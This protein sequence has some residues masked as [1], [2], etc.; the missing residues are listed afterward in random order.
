MVTVTRF[1]PFDPAI[2]EDPYPAYHRLRELRP[3]LHDETT[4]TW[5]LS[6]HRD[7]AW[8]LRDDRFSSDRRKGPSFE[9][10]PD[11]YPM[12]PSMLFVDPPEHTRL[13]GLVSRAFTP[14][15]VDQLRGRVEE[16]TAFL[17]DQA[18]AARAFDLVELFA[19][20][21]PVVV[22]AELLGV[23]PE[24]RLR[25]QE[26]S[27][28]LIRGLDPVTD[29]AVMHDLFL[30]REALHAYLREIVERR[31]TERRDDLIS[32]LLAL[33]ELSEPELLVMCQLLLV[34]GHETTVNLLGNGVLTLLE[35]PDQVER[36]L[37]EP[38]L[39]RPAVEELLR[40]TSPVQ[41][42]GRLALADVEI[43]GFTV[44]AGERVMGLVGAANRDP[45]V[46]PDPDRLDLG[47]DPNPHLSFGRGIHFCLG[48]PLARLEAQVAL[49]ALFGRFPGLR[50]AGRPELRDMVVLRG[51]SRLPVNV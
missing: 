46:F 35:N 50:L 18:E 16:V 36:L 19:Y 31:R 21:L 45:S 12:L 29:P 2:R 24:D 33:D 13:R 38:D 7:V 5:I 44:R 17:L 10:P 14:R 28:R 23:P 41:F 20:P 42:T 34:A 15:M 48:A 6:R 39:A 26:W 37:A 47:R 1:D 51:L 32:G 22:I 4:G 8:F 9:P 11:P 40:Y 3:V 49:P 30:A 43:D 27:M 25:F